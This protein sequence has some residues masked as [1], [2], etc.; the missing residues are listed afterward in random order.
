M[1][2]GQRPGGMTGMPNGEMPE[3]FTMPEGETMPADFEGEMPT[4]PE[5][6]AM[7]EGFGGQMPEAQTQSGGT[8]DSTL[9][10]MQDQVN[11]FSGITAVTE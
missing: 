11:A 5:G 3:D 9:F 2:G 7:P 1:G 8:E 4:M 6:E 10:Y